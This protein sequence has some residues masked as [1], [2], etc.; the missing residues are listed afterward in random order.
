[1]KKRIKE[2]LVVEGHHDSE[3]LRRFYDCDTIETG[4]LALTKDTLQLIADTQKRRGVIVFTDPDSPGNRIRKEINDAVPGCRNAFVDKADART[5]KKVGIEHA[6]REILDAALANLITMEEVPSGTLTMKDLYE[7]GLA[8]RTDS[9]VKREVLGRR[10]HLGAGTAKT[11][12][13]RLNCLGM[14]RQQL[15][16]ELENEQ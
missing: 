8:G 15:I 5:S 7:L 12:C 6:C 14:N 1:M 3:R 11:M 9:A 4:G 10:L 13:H 2:V 16:E